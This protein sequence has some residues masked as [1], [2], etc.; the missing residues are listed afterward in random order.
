MFKMKEGRTAEKGAERWMRRAQGRQKD[1][2]E[3]ADS[4]LVPDTSSRDLYR[5][6]NTIV[7]VEPSPGLFRALCLAYFSIR[8]VPGFLYSKTRCTGQSVP[9]TVLH[10]GRASGLT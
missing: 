9:E 8:E 4:T 10:V 2:C 7:R 1:T 6:G 5:H 3:L